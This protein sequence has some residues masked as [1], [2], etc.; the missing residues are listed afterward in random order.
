MK[1]NHPKSLSAKILADA[2]ETLE[3]L[4]Q[5]ETAPKSRPEK[6]RGGPAPAKPGEKRTPCSL[7]HRCGGWRLQNLP[8]AEP[9]SSKQRRV[10]KLQ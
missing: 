4:E 7:A 3:K 2:R 8:Y 10:G 5:E 1:Q 9:L 6:S